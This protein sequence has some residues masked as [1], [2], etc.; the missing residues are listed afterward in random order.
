MCMTAICGICHHKSWTGCGAHI[1]SVMD[2][3][4]RE[5]WCTCSPIDDSTDT[6]YPPKAG[7][8]FAKSLPPK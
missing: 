5:D 2:T 4:D 6:K 7:T 3:T 1:S 8:G